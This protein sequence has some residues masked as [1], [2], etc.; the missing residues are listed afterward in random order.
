MMYAQT[1]A[2]CQKFQMTRFAS[3]PNNISLQLW[4][5]VA[6]HKWTTLHGDFSCVNQGQWPWLCIH[7]CRK[8]SHDR[9]GN[10][11]VTYSILFWWYLGA[12]SSRGGFLVIHRF[13]QKLLLINDTDTFTS[14]DSCRPWSLVLQNTKYRSSDL[15]NY[16]FLFLLTAQFPVY[17]GKLGLLPPA[18]EV[19]EG[20]VFTH[21]CL[22]MGGGIP[23]CLAA[24]LGGVVS[25]HALQVSR[26]T[27]RGELR[28]LSMG[29]SRPTPK[30]EVEGSGLGGLL[31]GECLLRGV[32]TPGGSAPRGYLPGGSAPR[33]VWRPPVMATAAGS[34]HPTGMHSCCISNG[35][36]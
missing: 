6:Q 8:V 19:C 4:T 36:R 33:G 3:L 35:M 28:G 21:V 12:S 18:N 11:T 16:S 7:Q 25:Q 10:F 22:S 27:P 13:R 32:P 14:P 34:T 31:P 17:R 15:S 1:Y 23:A 26:P 29:A 5:D 9:P 2:T 30:G 20:Y 24:G